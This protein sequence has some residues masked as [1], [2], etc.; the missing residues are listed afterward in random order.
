MGKSKRCDA[1]PKLSMYTAEITTG[2]S[3][4]TKKANIPMPY[5]RSRKESMFVG[6]DKE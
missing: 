6:K 4:L 2:K 1:I 3:M 5:I